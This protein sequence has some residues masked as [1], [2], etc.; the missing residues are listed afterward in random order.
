[1]ERKD[2]SSIIVPSNSEDN[3]EHC[4][5]HWEFME[6]DI[7]NIKFSLRESILFWEKMLHPSTFVLN[8]LRD[9]YLL[10]FTKTPPGFY[11]E[12]NLSALKHAD[13][14]GEAVEKLLSSGFIAELPEPA[15]CCNPLTVADKGKLR[16]VLDLRHINTYL[17]LKKFKYEDLKIVAEIFEQHDY[18]IRFDL[19]SGYHHIDIHPEHQQFLGFH[20]VFNGNVHR[21]FCFTV[22]PFGLASAGYV[23]TKMLR[24]LT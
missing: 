8:I 14:V 21:H 10:P 7:C 13:F 20:W 9:G 22:L 24:P 3:M 18:F 17:V 23:F 16:L 11:A 6:G 4:H 2:T 15:Y 12:N 19:T 5:R 1:M